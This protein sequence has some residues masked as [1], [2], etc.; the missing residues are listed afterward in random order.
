[1][2]KN[3][4]S[5]QS[6]AAQQESTT[7]PSAMKTVAQSLILSQLTPLHLL[8]EHKKNYNNLVVCS[9]QDSLQLCLAKMAKHNILSLAISSLSAVR[10]VALV[11]IADM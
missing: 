4:S 7:T 5:P 9:P 8:Q 1:M 11:N 2:L 6:A 10:L 3:S